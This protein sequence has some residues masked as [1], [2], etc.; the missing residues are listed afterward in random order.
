M[1]PFDDRFF[2]HPV[3]P[4]GGPSLNLARVTVVPNP[5]RAVEAWNPSGGQEI[6]FVNLPAQ[7]RIR[8]YTLA[9]DLVRDIRHTIDPSE[10]VTAPWDQSRDFEAWDLKNGAGR[11]VGSGVY[12]Y[13]V[14]SGTFFHQ[15]RFV[16]IR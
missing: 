2:A 3:A 6:H 7:A 8:I 10:A 9:G 13:R 4:T 5:Y 12:I 11:D 16:V 15:S 14:E 1:A